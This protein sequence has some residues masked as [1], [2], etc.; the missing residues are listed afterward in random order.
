[1]AST[2]S[3]VLII[4]TSFSDDALRDFQR[5]GPSAVFIREL[6]KTIARILIGAIAGETATTPGLFA[7]VKVKVK[8]LRH[9]LTCNGGSPT[10]A[11]T[12]GA[13]GSYR[14]FTHVIPVMSGRRLY[15]YLP[16]VR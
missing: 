16:Y 3:D 8:R 1:M 2:P 4:R 9:G 15:S 13:L 6:E 5:R 7:K 12:A 10:G 14:R 11:L